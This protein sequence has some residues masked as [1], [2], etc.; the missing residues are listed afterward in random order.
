MDPLAERGGTVS[1]TCRFRKSH[2]GRVLGAGAV[3]VQSYR[4]AEVPYHDLLFLT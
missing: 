4:P 2:H 3:A 1:R